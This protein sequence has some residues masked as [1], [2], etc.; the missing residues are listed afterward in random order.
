VKKK[1][2]EVCG[3]SVNG[4]TPAN[5]VSSQ[6][7]LT[8]SMSTLSSSQIRITES[9]P[10]IVDQFPFAA[11]EKKNPPLIPIIGG[12]ATF[13]LLLAG[14]IFYNATKVTYVNVEADMTLIG[15]ECYDISWGFFDIPGGQVALK[16]D[17]V[18]IAYA[19]YPSTG[20]SSAYLGCRFSTTFYDVPT[21]G[22]FYSFGLA[23]GRRGTI[24]KSREEMVTDGWSFSVSLG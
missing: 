5:S 20:D 12:A 14:V 16:V 23:S 21:N 24:D 7:S 8:P 15:T 3:E 17:G 11:R 4:P 22:S 1:F 6:I 10:A 19:N 2:C 13:V 18:P 9:P